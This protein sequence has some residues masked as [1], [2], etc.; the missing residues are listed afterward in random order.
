[1]PNLAHLEALRIKLERR[2]TDVAALVAEL[3]RG[4]PPADAFE[5][6]VAEGLQ[7]YGAAARVALGVGGEVPG[8]E[9]PRARGPAS[10]L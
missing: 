8:E 10:P 9:R 6:A 4:R 2:G 5:T 7:N 3:E 1:M